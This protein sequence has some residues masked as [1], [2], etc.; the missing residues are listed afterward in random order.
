MKEDPKYDDCKNKLAQNLT[1]VY[2]D[3]TIKMIKNCY[4]NYIT[5]SKNQI[6]DIMKKIEK[7]YD[8]EERVKIYT[9]N[10][11]A[12]SENINRYLKDLKNYEKDKFKNYVVSFLINYLI[13]DNFMISKI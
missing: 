1:Q 7:C 5:D 3:F 2:D 12:C 10:R 9:E 8:D 6:Y 13:A 11:D 4:L